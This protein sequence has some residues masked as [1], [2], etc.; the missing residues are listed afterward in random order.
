M[1]YD[2]LRYIRYPID[3]RFFLRFL[4]RWLR[5]AWPGRNLLRLLHWFTYVYCVVQ[6]VFFFD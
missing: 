2:T 5:L 3:L 4:G 1:S 6:Y